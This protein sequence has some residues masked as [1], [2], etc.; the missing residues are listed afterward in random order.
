MEYNN[1]LMQLFSIKQKLI[2]ITSVNIKHKKIQNGE[3][4]NIFKKN[5]I[6]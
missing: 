6:I 2:V 1:L 5:P 3:F 4:V